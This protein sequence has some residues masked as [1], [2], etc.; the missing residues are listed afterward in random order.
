V[1]QPRVRVII[2]YSILPSGTTDKKNTAAGVFS[3]LC[4]ILD[5]KNKKE[6][7]G[8]GPSGKE[9]EADT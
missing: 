4:R 5:A 8:Q 6:D 3:S 7:H 2:I 1:S 9:I